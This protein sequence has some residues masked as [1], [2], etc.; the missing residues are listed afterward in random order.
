[1]PVQPQMAMS[2]ISRA[3]AGYALAI[4]TLISFFNYLDR[5][6]VAVLV[7]PIKRDLHLSDTQMGLVAGFAF[8]MLYTLL[9]L[10]L[11]RLADKSNRV[12]LLSICLGLWSLMTMLTGSVRGFVEMFAVRVGVGIG[13]AG[14]VPASHSLIGDLYP[15]ARRAFAISMFQAGGALG[16]SIGLAV[17]GVIADQWG[18]R[19]CLAVVGF[20]GLPLAL[21][22]IT[23][24]HEP[25]RKAHD[26]GPQTD[27][28]IFAAIKGLLARPAFVHLMV[29]VSLGAF[30][31]Y[32]ISQWV[33][34]FFVRTHHL[35]LTQVGAVGGLAGSIA[36]VAGV[37]TGGAVMIRLG[38]RD[39]RWELWWPML[40]YGLS[41][42][43][44]LMVFISGNWMVAFGFQFLA[45]FSASA[46]VGVAMSAVQSFAEPHR[47]ATAVALVLTLSSFLGLGIGPVGI[48]AASDLL[49]PYAG[50]DSLRYALM[51]STLL[52]LWSG[53]HFWLA[54]RAAGRSESANVGEPNIPASHAEG[55]VG[56]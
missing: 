31:I 17:A 20:M 43:I 38:K 23:T 42:P 3:R 39:R 49:A 27:E 5:M 8:A 32:G 48:G 53:L 11:A 45:A 14:C 24:V 2:E 15:G 34:A 18:W 33:P 22:A 37:L 13:E 21:L 12:R 9:G 6:V 52:M 54:A 7:E 41:G 50:A 35:S 25:P 44:Y 16:L 19:V 51:G 1:M 4:L 26:A 46:G 10:P 47:R 55:R 28:N 29:A 36:G 56:I 40:G 30:V